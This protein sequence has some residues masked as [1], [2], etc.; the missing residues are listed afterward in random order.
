MDKN[1]HRPAAERVN[2]SRHRLAI[3]HI[4]RNVFHPRQRNLRPVAG[5]HLR[6]GR[7]IKPA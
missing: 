3:G 5:D 1:I 4:Q 2:E 6:P 7:H